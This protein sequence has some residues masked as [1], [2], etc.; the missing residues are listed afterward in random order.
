M[1][2]RTGV[3]A[4]TPPTTRAEWD[5][6][7]RKVDD[8]GHDVLLLPDHLGQWPPLS[9]LVAAASVSDRLRFG[10]QVLNNEFWN[11][12][13]LAREA[14]AADVLTGGRLEL[15]FGA[16]HTAGEFAAAGIA[17][18]RPAVRIARLAEAVPLV[19]RLL[20]G[21]TV[22][23]DGAY[24]LAAASLDLATAQDRIPFMVGGNG[25]RLLA[26]AAREADTVSF[27]GFT[28]GPAAPTPTC[29]TSPGTAWPS[30]SPTSATTP[31]TASPPGAV[32]A[33]PARRGHR[34]PPGGGRAVGGWRARRG[35]AARQ[36]VRAAR[37]PRRPGRA[38]G[39]AGRGRG[40]LRHDLRALCRGPGFWG[41]PPPAGEPTSATWPQ[42]P[43]AAS[44]VG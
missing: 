28:A 30:A 12:V 21:E 43:D 1:S 13:L 35:A 36:P 26:L 32:G 31:A 41:D 44:L 38:G 23:H 8:L 7:V 10:V 42:P 5:D 24:R 11:P 27:V 39:P 40:H 9:P 17:Y 14:A 22:D 3:V 6:R 4:R 16:G 2:L 37:Q 20:A 25:D 15:G 34:R 29:P 33:G 18:E 19:R